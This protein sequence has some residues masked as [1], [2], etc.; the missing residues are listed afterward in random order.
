MVIL[1][2]LCISIY[3][4]FC[5]FCKDYLNYTMFYKFILH[6]LFITTGYIWNS[7]FTKSM[8]IVTPLF[9]LALSI[10]YI[11]NVWLGAMPWMAWVP[12]HGSCDNIQ[13]FRIYD[14]VFDMYNGFIKNTVAVKLCVDM[15]AVD[16]VTVS[17]I[18]M[19]CGNIIVRGCKPRIDILL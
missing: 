10:E 11:D 2:I 17:F 19:W 15:V 6:Y 12:F 16:F 1:E 5:I 8:G 7:T 14:L 9:V 18:I 4:A 13:K 3:V